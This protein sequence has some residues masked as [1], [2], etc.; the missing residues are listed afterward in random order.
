PP[1]TSVDH[2]VRWTPRRRRRQGSDRRAVPGG[3]RLSRLQ[4]SP[5]HPGLRPAG[6]ADDADLRGA[7]PMAAPG[8]LPHGLRGILRAQPAA[9]DDGR[10]GATVPGAADRLCALA[11]PTLRRRLADRRAPRQ[12]VARDDQR[13]LELLGPALRPQGVRHGKRLL[14]EGIGPH[15]R[16][17]MFGTDQRAGSGT[18]VEIY[19]TMD[20]VGLGESVR[21]RLIGG[22]A[23]RFV[24]TFWPDFDSRDAK[25]A[26]G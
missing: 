23:E 6:S 7:R 9:R 18:L 21:E 5:V 10:A 14:L 15:S 22:T 11:L 17:I 1:A 2:P 26:R 12:R 24:K 25:N 16:R 3:V 19:Q 13:L 4:V 8:R 20:R